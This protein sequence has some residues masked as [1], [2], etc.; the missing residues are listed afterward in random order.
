[1]YM[2][3]KPT[4][5][6]DMLSFMYAQTCIIQCVHGFHKK[7]SDDRSILLPHDPVEQIRKVFGDN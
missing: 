1:M 3:Y 6:Q 5:M 2:A 4:Y 7:L